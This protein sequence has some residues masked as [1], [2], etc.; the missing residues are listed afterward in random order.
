MLLEEKLYCILYVV[1]KVP[2]YKIMFQERE[3]KTEKKSII[4]TFGVKF[5]Y[6]DN[7]IKS[8]YVLNLF[9]S[10]IVFFVQP[11]VDIQYKT[12]SVLIGVLIS[13]IKVKKLYHLSIS[14]ILIIIKNKF[15]LFFNVISLA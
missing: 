8:L 4:N 10:C 6:K 14:H 1:P 5:Y 9:H 13:K 15:Y 12:F 7:K 3:N 11:S 2:M